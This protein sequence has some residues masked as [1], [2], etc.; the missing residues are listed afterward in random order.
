MSL[1]NIKIS[2]LQTRK[3]VKWNNYNEAVIPAWVAD[4][5][6]PVAP[7]AEAITALVHAGQGG[8][9]TGEQ[10]RLFFPCTPRSLCVSLCS[11]NSGAHMRIGRQ[12]RL[13]WK[14]CCDSFKGLARRCGQ[15][16]FILIESRYR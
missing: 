9:D 10:A 11:G 5:D 12:T 4:M 14:T 16:G 2:D 6:F 7:D 3:G 8:L 15:T 1:K 13:H